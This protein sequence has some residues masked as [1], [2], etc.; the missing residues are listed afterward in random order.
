MTGRPPKQA[1]QRR[2]ERLMLNFTPAERDELERQAEAAGLTLSA[3]CR[4]C[5]LGGDRPTEAF[6]GLAAPPP[7]LP[8]ELFNELNRIGINL[9]QLTR[10]ANTH[11]EIPSEVTELCDRIDR[12]L[13]RSLPAPGG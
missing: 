1:A 8:S 5:L 13:V 7:P 3:W 11:G 12:L 6:T 4:R 10:H 9:N 2:T